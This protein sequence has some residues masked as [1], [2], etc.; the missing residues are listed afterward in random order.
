M[1]DGDKPILAR[2]L[3]EDPA[4]INQFE[5]PYIIL[6]AETAWQESAEELMLRAIHLVDEWGWKTVN[7]AY[8][9]YDVLVALC[10]NPD[11]KRKNETTDLAED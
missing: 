11:I 4:I 9:H 6:I 3:V 1:S 2:K 10:H 7:I 5:S 8:R